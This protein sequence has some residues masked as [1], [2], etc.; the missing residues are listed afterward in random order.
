MTMFILIVS[1]IVILLDQGIKIAIT[2][3]GLNNSIVII[4]K[5]FSFTYVNN[6]GAA[7]S[8]LEGSRL[9]LIIL[10]IAILLVIYIGF[11]KDKKLTKIKNISYGLLIGGIVGNL[12]DRI[13][14]GYVIDYLDFNILGYNYPIFNLADSCIVISIFILICLNFKGVKK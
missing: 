7:R 12:L 3:I 10:A 11:I 1:I 13:I 8:I 2:N 5:I 9:L 4:K 14:H 6:Y